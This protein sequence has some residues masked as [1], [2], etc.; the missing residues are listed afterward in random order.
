V[1]AAIT[2]LKY[3]DDTAD[4][5]EDYEPGT[6]GKDCIATVRSLVNVVSA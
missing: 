5:Y 6:F 2:N 4:G 3:I 1:L